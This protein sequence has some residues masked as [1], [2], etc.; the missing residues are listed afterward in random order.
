[1]PQKPHQIK[2]N[3]SFEGRPESCNPSPLLLI[4]VV[5]VVV[6]LISSQIFFGIFATVGKKELLT[7]LALEKGS[8]AL[9][10]QRKSYPE[11]WT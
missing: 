7:K 1:M 2:T 5:A 8:E 6:I 9:D 3:H 10:A 4:R 11:K